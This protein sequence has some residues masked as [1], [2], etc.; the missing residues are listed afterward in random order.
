MKILFLLAHPDD[1]AFGPAGTV[2]KLANDNEV[3]LASLCNGRRP[4]A[5]VERLRCDG[6]K[7]SADILG[8]TSQIWNNDDCSLEFRDVSKQVDTIIQHH[9]PDVVYTHSKNDIHRDHR[10]IAESCLVACRPKVNSSVNALYFSEVVPSTAWG[11]NEFG[12]FTPNVY[13]DITNVIDIKQKVLE[14]Y[15]TEIYEYPDARSIQNVLNV[16][17][18]RGSQVGVQYAEAFQ[19]VFSRDH[20]IL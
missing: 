7:Q 11:M 5:D 12:T 2:K 6:F 10:M 13:S 20:K 18:V 14:I 16:A 8:A 4:G 9:Q 3:I 1:E 19:L 17:S 15:S